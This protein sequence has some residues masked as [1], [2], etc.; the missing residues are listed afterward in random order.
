MK[1]SQKNVAELQQQTDKLRDGRDSRDSRFLKLFEP[2]H[3][4]YEKHL[5]RENEIDF[6]DMIIKATQYLQ[7]GEYQKNISYIIID[8]F[9]DI[10]FGRYQL[11]AAFKKQNPLCKM[12]AVGDD[13]QSIYRFAGSDIDLF[14]SFEKYFGVTAQ[15]KIETTYRYAEPL[16]SF[17]S[18]FILKNPNQLEKQIK[19]SNADKQ[20]HYYYYYSDTGEGESDN[21]T[22]GLI[23]EDLTKEVP[24]MSTKSICLIGRYDFDL[25]NVLLADNN[26]KI[27]QER[28]EQKL[29]YKN[30]LKMDFITA[31]KSKGLEYDIVIIVN[32]KSGTYGFPCQIVDDEVL[33]LIL[34]KS[35]PYENSE[36]RRLFYVAMT[37]AKERCIFLVKENYKSKFT[38]EIE[39]DYKKRAILVDKSDTAKLA[40]CPECQKEDMRKIK[41]WSRGGQRWCHYSCKNYRYGCE[42]YQKVLIDDG[43]LI[44]TSGEYSF[45]IGKY[46]NSS[47]K[48][49]PESYLAWWLSEDKKEACLSQ[50]TKRLFL[51]QLK[52]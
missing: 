5:Q 49:V 45:K 18:N 35:D 48:D 7:K 51:H 24:K 26:F 29:I 44:K 11:L 34:S 47:I 19:N 3:Q 41:E 22:M 4:E 40:K 27:I 25:N 9:Q 37:R 10:S 33:N 46:K 12:F 43:L 2:L 21:I 17:S 32:N 13:W 16:I 1:G 20:T 15:L 36:E 42:F 6:N 8:E 30:K 28:R 31:H 39:T 14:T 38:H 23:C 52:R 50:N